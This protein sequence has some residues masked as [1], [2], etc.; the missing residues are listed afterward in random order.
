[1]MELLESANSENEEYK[2]RIAQLEE[3]FNM[4]QHQN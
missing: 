4:N 3:S 1:M 2:N